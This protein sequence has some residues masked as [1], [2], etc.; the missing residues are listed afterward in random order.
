MNMVS[1][2]STVDL[3]ELR[4]AENIE[5]TAQWFTV[6]K[7]DTLL[8]PGAAA[9]FISGLRSAKCVRD[10]VC[11]FD[12][13]TC[14]YEMQDAEFSLPCDIGVG[15]FNLNL[16]TLCNIIFDDAR[17]ERLVLT[18]L[19]SELGLRFASEFKAK[20]E[21]RRESAL[22][23]ANKPGFKERHNVAKQLLNDEAVLAHKLLATMPTTTT[24][25]E[26]L[27]RARRAATLKK[28]AKALAKQVNEAWKQ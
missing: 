6:G 3:I 22:R 27:A 4:L 1:F 17:W 21:Q 18:F 16:E 11:F 19:K 9:T 26:R 28:T 14:A 23:R 2:N 15:E 8:I 24:K 13:Y 20:K 25:P 10:R 5:E 12:E 7:T